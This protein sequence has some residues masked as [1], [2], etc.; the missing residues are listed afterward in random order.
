MKQIKFHCVLFNPFNKRNFNY[1]HF[2][3]TKTVVKMLY[4]IIGEYL[5]NI[6]KSNMY[7]WYYHQI[8]FNYLWEKYI[9]KG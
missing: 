7:Y 1:Y 6:I 8:D 2:D 4:I 3:I 5:S 9:L